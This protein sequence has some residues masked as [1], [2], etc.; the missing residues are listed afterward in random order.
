MSD[1]EYLPNTDMLAKKYYALGVSYDFG[2]DGYPCDK[3]KAQKY[4]RA[5]A[6]LGYKD[7]LLYLSRTDGTAAAEREVF[8]YHEQQKSE[9]ES[10]FTQRRGLEEAIREHVFPCLVTITTKD[11]TVGTGFF[12]HSDWLVTNAHVTPVRELLNSSMLMDNDKRAYKA[13]VIGSYHRPIENMAAPDVVIAKLKSRARG[14][15]KSLPMEFNGDDHHQDTIS[16]YVFFDED[17]NSLQIKFLR[18]KSRLGEYPIKYECEDGT[19]PRPGCSGS[20]VIE[21]RVATNTQR[22]QFQTVGVVYARCVND[23][24]GGPRLVCAIPVIQDFSQI[25]KIELQ[26]I[27]ADGSI[28][29]AKTCRDVDRGDDSRFKSYMQEADGEIA[30]RS[31]LL[32]AFNEGETSLNI[33]LPDGLEKLL[34]R[35]IIAI[36]DSAFSS[37]TQRRYKI[38]D[39]GYPTLT[40]EELTQAYE[41]CIKTIRDAPTIPLQKGKIINTKYFRVDADPV[42][43]GGSGKKFWKLDLQDNIGDGYKANGEPISSKFA[44]V[45]IPIEEKVILGAELADLFTCS[46]KDKTPQTKQMAAA[47]ASSSSSVAA[48]TPKETKQDMKRRKKKEK[49]AKGRAY[50]REQLTV[51]TASSSAEAPSATA[52]TT[53]TKKPPRPW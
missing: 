28:R 37:K 18:L 52:S 31:M 20:P 49:K 9:A 42:R 40:K 45:R 47:A 29:Y 24:A 1:L 3:S 8:F 44:I 23:Q 34:G 12:Q 17:T 22:W 39:K 19:E 10:I 11:G 35:G 25:F 2:T 53:Q 26:G 33:D 4:F 36:E 46:Q 14:N 16:F 13:E 50:E 15:V 43:D 41:Q 5:S 21:A 30:C 6:K 38:E 27:L 48:V 51:T 32:K 7:A